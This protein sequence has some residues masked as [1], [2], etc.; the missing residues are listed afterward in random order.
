MDQLKTG[1]TTHNKKSN[2]ETNKQTI[3]E[4]STSSGGQESALIMSCFV[5][6]L[7]NVSQKLDIDISSS[8]KGSQTFHKA[9][10]FHSDQ[11]LKFCLIVVGLK[12]VSDRTILDSK[13]VNND[14][15]I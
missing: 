14:T 15:N 12:P 4:K 8:T 1:I 13:C 7:A 2:R 3:E 11:T 6:P 10:I 9:P 5:H